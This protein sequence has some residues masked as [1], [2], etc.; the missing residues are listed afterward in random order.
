MAGHIVLLGDSIFDNASYVDVDEAVIE[1]LGPALPRGWRA[2]LLAVDGGT[3]ASVF[4]QIG[5]IDNEA[6]HLV[7]S[8]GGNDALWTAG[9]VFSHKSHDVRHALE[10]VGRACAEFAREYR[11]LIAELLE[12]RLPLAVCTIYDAIPGLGP[13]ELAGLCLF[14]DTIT[15]TAF[16]RNLTLIDLRLICNEAADYSSVS[17][18]EPSA[19][20][21][22]K[23]ARA[24]TRATTGNASSSCVIA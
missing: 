2:T 12:L 19:R 15:R 7:L 10:V 14:N 4:D 13:S 5:R 1:Q 21:S 3:V 17:P 20:G 16:Q 6:T 8:V 22:R 24:I 9:N 18:I 23:I 11:R